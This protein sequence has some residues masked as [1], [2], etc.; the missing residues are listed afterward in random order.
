MN[1]HLNTPNEGLYVSIGVLSQQR[2]VFSDNLRMTT[3]HPCLFTCYHGSGEEPMLIAVND[4]GFLS[5]DCGML[6]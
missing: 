2:H 1:V 6:G 5:G 3:M 4:E